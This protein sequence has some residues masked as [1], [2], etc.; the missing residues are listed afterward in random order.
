MLSETESIAEV[1]GFREVRTTFEI[2][3]LM[4]G[5]LSSKLNAGEEFARYADC[6][7]EAFPFSWVVGEVADRRRSGEGKDGREVGMGEGD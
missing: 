7:L 5:G 6:S 4:N 1:R 2:E 3:V